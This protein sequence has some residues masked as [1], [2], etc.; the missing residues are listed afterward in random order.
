MEA[1][2]D[3]PG[4]PMRARDDLGS[5]LSAGRGSEVSE[6]PADA[7]VCV[8]WAVPMWLLWAAEGLNAVKEP[9]VEPFW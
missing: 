1:S 3:G 7:H 6:V 2:A 4:L 8:I 9:D 5:L